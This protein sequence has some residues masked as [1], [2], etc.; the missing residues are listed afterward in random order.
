M[1]TGRFNYLCF[2]GQDFCCAMTRDIQCR[3]EVAEDFSARI[4]AVAAQS[5]TLP[6]TGAAINPNLFHYCTRLIWRRQW[7]QSKWK[8]N[9]YTLKNSC[10]LQILLLTRTTHILMWLLL[11]QIPP[12]PPPPQGLVFIAPANVFKASSDIF[13][14]IRGFYR[15][16][17]DNRVSDA[18]ISRKTL[19]RTPDKPP[20]SANSS[21]FAY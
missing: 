11:I 8:T 19:E 5:G 6:A 4:P 2:S 10:N 21:L 12:P 17:V 20:A 13:M 15:G 9:K 7:K 1:R 18:A 3:E 14:P 16:G